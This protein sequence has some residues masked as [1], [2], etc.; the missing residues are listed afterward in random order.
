M[1]AMAPAVRADFS[2]VRR[3]LWIVQ[4]KIWFYVLHDTF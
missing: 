2:A 4:G 1:P 3:V